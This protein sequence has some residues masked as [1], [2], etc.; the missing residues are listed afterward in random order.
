[1]FLVYIYERTNAQKLSVL[2]FGSKFATG[3]VMTAPTRTNHSSHVPAP[4][5]QP[6]TSVAILA[7]YGGVDKA[8]QWESFVL[9]T[10]DP[11]MGQSPRSVAT[12]IAILTKGK[13]FFS[14]VHCTAAVALDNRH[15]PGGRPRI[16]ADAIRRLHPSYNSPPDG[17]LAPCSLSC[18]SCSV[19]VAPVAGVVAVPPPSSSLG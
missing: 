18:W 13:C 5:P 16:L 17:V 2:I 1:M 11:V 6:I 7:C 15:V 10:L 8:R 14:F 9:S 4:A 19:S 12:P 3:V